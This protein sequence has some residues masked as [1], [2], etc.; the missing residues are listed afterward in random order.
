VRSRG[1]LEL[2]RTAPWHA[3]LPAL[4][5]LL[6]AGEEPPPGQIIAP[7]VARARIEDGAYDWVVAFG[8]RGPSISWRSEAREMWGGVDAPRMTALEVPDGTLGVA[9]IAADSRV[10]RGV[11]LS[12]LLLTFDLLERPSF[13][14]LRGNSGPSKV[15]RF[16]LPAWHG[17]SAR[18]NLLRMPQLRAF[19]LEKAWAASLAPGAHPALTRGL[20]LHYGAQELSSPYETRAQQLEIDEDALRS[21]KEAVPGPGDLDRF[22]AALWESLAWLFHE[23]RLPESALVFLEPVAERFAPWPSL[24]RTLAR[25][26]RE[27]L[28][29]EEALRFADRALHYAPNDIELLVE[30]GGAALELGDNPRGIGYL[31]RALDLQRSR[32][33]LQRALGLALLSAG[34]ERGRPLLEPLLDDHPED[35]ELR[36][37][38]FGPSD[39]P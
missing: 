12:P 38:L 31:E 27:L 18:E 20:A 9:W 39:D 22:T 6:F 4:E 34:D 35:L 17:P 3:S 14:L 19:E 29:P 16:E 24:D 10:G 5:G 1:A 15:P 2:D 23:K 8:A 7:G 33:D 37:A 28:E 32:P 13:G 25:A 21:F 36:Q 26:Y 30:A 11:E